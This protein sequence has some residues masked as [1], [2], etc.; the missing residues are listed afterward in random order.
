MPH[1][2]PVFQHRLI[3]SLMERP[4][5]HDDDVRHPPRPESPSSRPAFQSAC[6]LGLFRRESCVPLDPT[7]N[8]VHHLFS[9]MTSHGVGG[10]SG[11]LPAF[12]GHKEVAEAGIHGKLHVAAPTQRVL[13]DLV[14]KTWFI[15]CCFRCP[16]L[17]RP[18]KTGR[19]I[20]I[21]H[22]T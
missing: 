18:G 17:S 20:L 12:Y 11:L 6:N 1:A 16:L 19:K 9:H 8:L 3:I 4:P 21:E 10:G 15:G 2:Q 14:T 5:Y 22:T 7:P 13:P